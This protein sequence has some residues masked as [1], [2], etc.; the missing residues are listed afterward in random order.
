MGSKGGGLGGKKWNVG[1]FPKYSLI[2]SVVIK[3]TGQIT[4]PTDKLNYL[5]RIVA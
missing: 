1:V 5:K 4:T 2:I 3:T